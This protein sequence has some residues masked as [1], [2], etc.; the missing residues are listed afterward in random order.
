MHYKPFV[1]L[2]RFQFTFQANF[3]FGTNEPRIYH[4][5]RH[6]NDQQGEKGGDKI[7]PAMIPIRAPYFANF[8]TSNRES[9]AIRQYW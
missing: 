6:Q 5:P 4:R 1:K 8:A 9:Q 2:F 3:I 7:Q